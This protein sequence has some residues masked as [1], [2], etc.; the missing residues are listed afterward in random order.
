MVDKR[1]KKLMI[2]YVKMDISSKDYSNIEDLFQEIYL[3][4]TKNNIDTIAV[5]SP[6]V[7]YMCFLYST[8]N[9][10]FV[11]MESWEYVKQRGNR[12]EW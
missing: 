10:A 1:L 2:P 9:G 3:Y 7:D 6:V 4:R 5:R 8:L 12:I 11:D